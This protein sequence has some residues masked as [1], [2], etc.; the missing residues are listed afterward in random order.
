MGPWSIA[1]YATNATNQHYIDAINALRRIAGAPRQY[2]VR[3]SR[4]F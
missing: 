4:T 3:I 2:G 1:G